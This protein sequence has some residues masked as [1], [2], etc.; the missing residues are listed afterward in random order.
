[1]F[2]GLFMIIVSWGLIFQGWVICYVWFFFFYFFGVGGEY[3]IIVI[4]FFEN[5]VFV[6]KF[7]ICEDCFYCGCCVIMVF[8][9]QGWG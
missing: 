5:V 7:L 2:I 1:M 9:M 8:F 6:G 3:F 4:L